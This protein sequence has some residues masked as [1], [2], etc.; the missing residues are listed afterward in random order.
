[1]ADSWNFWGLMSSPGRGKLWRKLK[2]FW[3][4]HE[5]VKS[6]WNFSQ[7]HVSW[8]NTFHVV[9]ISWFKHRYK[10]EIFLKYSWKC[11]VRQNFF[12]KNMSHEQLPF[13]WSTLRDSSMGTKLKCFWKTHETIM[14]AWIFSQKHLTNNY[15]SHDQNFVILAWVQNWNIYVKHMKL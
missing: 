11:V 8:T 5:K 12:T 6:A 14:F 7:K 13:M 10:V 3:K 9:Q 1:M 2:Y 15:F 4:T